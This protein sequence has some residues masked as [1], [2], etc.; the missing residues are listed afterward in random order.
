MK[1][2]KNFYK[3]HRIFVILMAV[4]LVCLIL[5]GTILIRY[6]YVND[7]SDKYGSRLEHIEDYKLESSRLNEI[8]EKYTEGTIE[9]VEIMLTGRIVYIH[10]IGN[11]TA[12]LVTCQEVA[13][14]ILEEFSEDEKKYYDFQ[15]TIK[16]SQTETDEGF[17]VSGAHNKSGT[18]LNWNNMR[19]VEPDP[20]D[21]TE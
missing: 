9:K 10:I 11:E 4:A 16:K 1:K 12:D 14:K 5:I 15:F 2:I 20:T 17:L 8:E 7:G 19:V 13:T 3:T 21:V 18:G 6:F